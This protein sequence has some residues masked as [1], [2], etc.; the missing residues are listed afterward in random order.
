MLSVFPSL[1]KTFPI[2]V[3]SLG[4]FFSYFGV[5][6]INRYG[7]VQILLFGAFVLSLCQFTTG[8]I[9]I[10]G[11]GSS[12]ALIIVSMIVFRS[13]FSFTLG[14]VPYLYTPE[15]IDPKI[16]PYSMMCSWAGSALLS[17]FFPIVSE[18]MGNPGWIFLTIGLL[19]LLSFVISYLVLIET[20]DKNELEIKQ[21]ID[22][23]NIIFKEYLGRIC[24][25]T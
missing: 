4:I 6:V 23:K 22:K 25:S 20:K 1:E 12:N 14:P 21:E 8:Y 9:F 19:G 10:W 3:N 7:R 24:E 15:V 17:L 11:D 2:L 18:V 16:V 13:V 5:Y